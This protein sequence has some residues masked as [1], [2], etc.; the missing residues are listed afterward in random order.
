M[1]GVRL[2]FASAMAL[3]MLGGAGPALGATETPVDCGS[4][5]DL[6]AA[7]DAAAP[8]DVL[9][10]SGTCVGTFQIAKGLVLQ[11]VSNAVLDAHAQGT[12]LTVDKGRVRVKNLTITGGRP[13]ENIV[14][15]ILN[16]GNLTLNHVTVTG[17][18]APTWDTNIGAIE[19]VG[20][21]LLLVRS[22][23]AGNE[24]AIGGIYNQ[25]A[26]ATVRKST[27]GPNTGS[28][29]VNVDVCLNEVL[30]V[31]DSTISN[32]TSDGAAGIEN[33]A[34][35]TIFRSTIANNTSRN[36]P[37]NNVHPSPGGIQNDGTISIVESTIAFNVGDH[38]PGGLLDTTGRTTI[39][40]TIL[41][42]NRAGNGLAWDCAGSITSN[43]YNLVST[44]RDP[45]TFPGQPCSLETASAPTDILGPLNPVLFVLGDYGGPTQTVKPGAKSPAVDAIPVDAL[46]T[47]GTTAL[48][49][50][51]GSTDQRGR[52]RPNGP[53]CDIGSVERKP[54]Q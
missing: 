42:V 37:S 27:I 47:D 49:P 8:G 15:G 46:T 50:A 35:A 2:V 16:S 25:C 45:S 43:G 29:I 38:D 51:S 11:G 41:G 24:G 36:S 13:L 48:C 53:A 54:K 33:Q 4:G 9:D 20:G 18:L 40:A 31:V 44:P 39:A 22:T 34:S 32:N 28:G 23:V 21:P 3:V 26:T 6:Q 5:A 17:N 14:G 1:V 52:P 10:I 30:T 19:N 12:T 7:I